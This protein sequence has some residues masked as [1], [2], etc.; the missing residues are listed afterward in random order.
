MENTKKLIGTVE[1]FE[2]EVTLSE[3]SKTGPVQAT[4]EQV[5]I[6]ELAIPLAKYLKDNDIICCEV[7]VSMNTVALRWEGFTAQ[8]YD[9]YS[10]IDAPKQL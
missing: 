2:T 7:I 4:R 3:V 5:A 9:D 6:A 8:Y 10:R 1:I